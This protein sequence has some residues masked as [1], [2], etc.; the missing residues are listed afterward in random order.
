VGTWIGPQ[1]S[2]LPARKLWIAFGQPSEGTIEVDDGAVTALVSG[3]KSLLAVGVKSL[4][5]DFAEGAAVEVKDARGS[6]IGKGLVRF[7]AQKLAEVVGR[8]SSEVGGEVIHRDDLV[9]LVD[10][11]GG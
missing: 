8:H 11:S 4:A 6:L 1:E 5:G 9:I 10:S 3:G 2:S 7:S